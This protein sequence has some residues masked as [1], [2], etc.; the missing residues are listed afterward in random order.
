M[1]TIY[2]HIDRKIKSFERKGTIQVSPIRKGI[3]FVW[4]D[5]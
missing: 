5:W 1:Y 3:L 2:I 4:K